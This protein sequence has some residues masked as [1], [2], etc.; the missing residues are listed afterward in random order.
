MM[1]GDGKFFSTTKKGD[2]QPPARV[3]SWGISGI[4]RSIYMRGHLAP[5]EFH[6][7]SCTLLLL[8]RG[9]EPCK[10]VLTGHQH[11]FLLTCIIFSHSLSAINR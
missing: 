10:Q 11:M 9:I 7:C 4:R 5:P 8:P 6:Q 3:T 2:F 1:S